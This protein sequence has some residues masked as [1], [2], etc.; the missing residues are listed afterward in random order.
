M[1]QYHSPPY[2]SIA[3]L[4]VAGLAQLRVVRV[5][6]RRDRAVRLGAPLAEQ[7]R[8]AACLSPAHIASVELEGGAQL[9]AR[10]AAR[11]SARVPTSRTVPDPPPSCRGTRRPSTSASCWA[12]RTA[13]FARS[14]GCGI[15]VGG[16]RRDRR[17]TRARRGRRRRAASPPGPRGSS[18]GRR[19]R[20]R[21]RG[22]AAPWR[23]AR[24]ARRRRGARRRPV[25]PSQV[26]D[27]FALE[28]LGDDHAARS[29]IPPPCDERCEAPRARCDRAARAA[30]RRPAAARRARRGPADPPRDRGRPAVAARPLQPQGARQGARPRSACKAKREADRAVLDQTGIRALRSEPVFRTPLPQ[31]RA[32]GARRAGARRRGRARRV[33]RGRGAPRA[34]GRRRG[35]ASRRA[36]MCYVCKTRL[37][38]AAP[39]LRSDVPAVRGAQLAQAQRRP[40]TCAAA[41]RSSPA[42]ASRSATRPRSCCCAPAPR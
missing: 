41:S 9:V 31:A 42:R 8:R 25:G 11:G 29:H 30:R 6:D 15:D 35:R 12:S 3:A 21:G 39:L 13:C 19:C 34:S 24:A 17:G 26:G 4:V 38:R 32:D 22:G 37:P 36:R 16:R 14:A 18:T 2:A 33:G 10:R 7:L 5:E 23:S 1:P 40:R 28:A 20:S 27:G